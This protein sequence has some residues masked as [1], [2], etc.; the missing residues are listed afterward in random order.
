[1]FKIESYVTP[2]LLSYVDKYVRDFKPADAQVSLWGGG[3][4]LHNLVLKADVLQQEVALPFTLVSGRI[5]EL[6][7]QV[8]WTKI[9]SEPIVVTIDTIECVL[10][11]NRPAPCDAN[12]PAETTSPK[13]QV[14]EAPPGY[15]QALVRR[16][17][18][19]IALRVHH[20][21]VKYVQDDIVMSL[22]VK[23]VAVDSAGASWHP[24]FADIDSSYPVI[25]RLVRLDDLTLCLDRADSDGKIRYYQEP[26]LYRCQLNFR[27]STK[28]VSAN[29][30]RASSL[31]IQLR[32]SKLGFSVTNDQLIL[33]IRLLRERTLQ[34]EKQPAPPAKTP[35]EPRETPTHTASQGNVSHAA[36]PV[37]Q[38]SWS[39]W[40][41]SW[42]PAWNDR[43]GGVEEAP[44]PATPLPIFI[45]AYLDDISLAYKIME[46]ESSTRKRARS[47]LELSAVHAAV[48]SSI[49]APT[50]MR[51]RFGT[52]LLT[53]CSHG[54][55]VCG[56]L[57]IN[58]TQ[59]LPTMYFKRAG[60]TEDREW[61]WPEELMNEAEKMEYAQAIDE[62]F[63][64]SPEPAPTQTTRDSVQS[65]RRSSA[66][67][68]ED[69][70]ETNPG[71]PEEPSPAEPLEDLDELWLKMAPVL[72]VE[73]NHERAPPQR[74]DN[75]YDN[76]PK[77]FE[78]S[79]WVEI[80]NMNVKLDPVEIRLC[81]G[82]IHRMQV[83]EQAFQDLPPILD[84]ELPIRKL[85]VE[86]NEALL[87][88]LPQRK[89]VI[90]VEGTN[91]TV[92]PFKHGHHGQP[93]HHERPAKFP[94]LLE[95]DIPSAV[96]VINGPLYPHRVCSAACQLPENTGPLFQGARLNISVALPSLQFRLVSPR[97]PQPRPCARTD[98]K[99]LL[100]ILLNKGYFNKRETVRLSYSMKIREA[101]ISGSAARLEAAYQVPASMFSSQ[102]TNALRY[103]SLPSDA[104][105]DEEAVTLDI[106]VE[107]VSARGYLTQSMNTHII[108]LQSARATAFH[109]PKGE[110]LKQAWICCAPESP[111][112]IPYLRL[113][114]QWCTGPVPDALD[115]L[116][117][118]TEP[119]AFS[120]D[121]LFVTFLAYKPHLKSDGFASS[122]DM[123]QAKSSQY[124]QRR[125]PTPPSS[126][127]RSSRG[128]ELVHV[129]TR[130]VESSSE[131]SEKKEQ[132]PEHISQPKELFTGQTLVAFYERLRRM[133]INIELGLVLVYVTST[134][135]SA[136][137]CV[138]IRDAM[139]RHAGI[140]SVLA[141]GLGRISMHSNSTRK[142]LW[143]DIR[144]DGPTFIKKKEPGASEID[145]D[146]F[147]WKLRL[148][149]MSCYTL[150][151]GSNLTEKEGLDKSA[152]GL[153]SQ[154]KLTTAGV[155][156]RTVLELTTTTVTLSVVTK[157]LQIKI[158][159]KTDRT[160]RSTTEK[161]GVEKVKYFQTGVD[162]HP[163]TLKEF[164]RGPVRR[165]TIEVEKKAEKK[166][167]IE[168]LMVGPVVSLGVHMHADTP[169]VVIRIAHDQVHIMGS[170]IHCFK[171]IITLL[172][173]QP[174]ANPR[175]LGHRSLIRTVSEV[176]EVRDSRSE[177][178]ISENPSE[179]I[180]IFE[181]KPTSD[182]A[183]PV[184][185]SFWFQWVVSRVT[186]VLSTTQ[187]KFAL[188]IDD[189]ISTVDLQEHY[190]QW[191]LK[192]SSASIRHY[193]RSPDEW[194]PGVLGGRVLEVREPTNLRDDGH[195]IS[196]TIT[197]AQI[198]NLPESWKAELHPKM[199]ERGPSMDTMWEV[200]ATLS[201]LEAVL[202]PITLEHV[203]LLLQQVSPR[204]YCVLTTEPEH[205]PDQSF[206][207]P[208]MFITAGGI[209]ILI[210]GEEEDAD[211]H[212]TFIFSMGKITVTPHPENPI[213]RRP[214]NCSDP[215]WASGNVE[216]EGRQYDVLVKNVAIKSAQ[217]RQ[218]II[219]ESMQTTKG[220]E[221]PAVKWTKPQEQSVVTPVLHAVDIGVVIAPAHYTSGILACG[222]AVEIN[223]LT[224]CAL[225]VS[226]EQLALVTDIVEDMQRAFEET[227]YS[228]PPKEEKFDLCPY[229]NLLTGQEYPDEPTRQLSTTSLVDDS[230]IDTGTST[231]KSTRYFEDSHPISKKVVS[232]VFA[233]QQWTNASEYLEV[234]FTMGMIEASLYVTDDASEEVAS[235]RPPADAKVATTD[236]R[237][238]VQTEQTN[239]E[240]NVQQ[241]NKSN[242]S[243]RLSRISGSGHSLTDNTRRED[244]A[245]T[246]INIALPKAAKSE[247]NLPLIHMTL[248]QPNLYYWKKKNQ[249]GLQA[250]LFNAWV[251]LGSG[252]TEGQWHLPLLSTAKGVPDPA[253][254]IPPALATMKIVAP[255]GP[256]LGSTARGTM[257][258]D[259]ERPVQLEV[260]LDRIR[261]IKGIFA[262]IDD[263]VVTDSS[264]ELP[265]ISEEHSLYRFRRYMTKHGME[266]LTLQTSQISVSGGEGTFGWDSGSIQIA[267]G[268][269]PSRV[270][271]RGLLCGVLC[272]AGPSSD[273]RHML[274]HPLQLGLD[275]QATWEAWRREELGH[276]SH[277]PSIRSSVN[278]DTVTLDLRPCD[279]VTVNDF[280]AQLQSF[281]KKSGFAQSRQDSGHTLRRRDSS[282]I[283]KTNSAASASSFN[284]DLADHYY[285]DDL[286]SGAFKIVSGGQLPMAY[287]VMV[288]GY[289]VSWRYPHPRAIT[290]IVAFP[291]PGLD[292]EVDCVLELYSPIQIKWMPHTYFKLPV[293]EPREIKLFPSPPEVVFALTWR[294]RACDD[295]TAMSRPFEFNAFDYSPRDD[296]LLSDVS[297]EKHTV[298]IPE[299]GVTAEQLSGVLRVDSYFAPRML[300]RVRVALRL[301]YLEVNL[302]NS[303]PNITSRA[304]AELEGY[305]VSRPLMR[306]H[307]VMSLI[308]RDFASNTHFR[309]QAGSLVVFE[310]KLSAD[311][312]ETSTGA[313][314]QMIEEF[315]VR[316]SVSLPMKKKP[317]V[318]V[319]TSRV[320]I[321]L[322][323]PRVRTL[324]ALVK[325]WNVVKQQNDRT[326]QDKPEEKKQ[327]SFVTKADMAR[328]TAT[329]LEG[330]VALWIH[331]S[332]GSA[333]RVGQEGTDEVVPLG[334]GARMAYRW[335]CPTAKKRLRFAVASPTTD[336]HWSSSIPFVA[337]STRVRLEDGESIGDG[338]MIPGAGIFM[339]VKVEETGASRTMH[340]VGRLTLAN[341]LRNNLLF[342]VRARCNV[343][344]QW[345]TV[346]SGELM[347]E[348]VGRTVI[349]GADC[350]MVLKIKFA[351][352]ET[353]WSG[354]IPLKECPKENVPWLV[355]VPSTGEVPYTSV[356][357]RVT[358]AR[359]DGRVL[360]TVWP[361]YVLHSALPLDTV[362]MITTNPTS[363]STAEL[364]QSSPPTL[365]QTAPGRGVCT[366][367]AAPGTTAARHSLSF[368][369]KNIDCPVTR[370]A[371][372][373]HYG[374][375][376][377]SVFD[378]RAPVADI[379]EIVNEVRQ[380]LNRSATNATS[381]WPYSLVTK[382]WPGTWQPAQLQPR[383]DVTV[384]YQAVRAGGG[385]SLEIQLYPVVL[386][387]NAA[388]IALTLRA[389]DA[390]PLC[391]LEPGHA[392]SL[393]SAVLKKP[394]FMSVEMGR[395]TF[396]SGQL[397]LAKEDPGR[398]GAPPPG[399]LA[400]QHAA[401]FAILCNHKVA[402]LTM[403][404]EIKENINVLGIS[405]SYVLLNRLD[406]DIL[407]S[408]IAVPMEMESNVIL[409]SS[410]Y[411]LVPPTNRDS[412]H[413]TP[414]ARFWMRGRWRGTCPTELRLYICLA[415]PNPT[416]GANIV[417]AAHPPVPIR[418]KKNMSRRAV[419]LVDWRNKS[420][421]V[422][423]TQMKQDGRFLIA[424][425]QDPC[426]QFVA[427]N[428][429][430]TTLSIAQP[431]MCNDE[432]ST[433]NTTA[434][435]EVSGT[436]WWC[437][438][439]PNA[440]IHYSTPEHC[441]RYPPPIPPRPYALPFL[442]FAKA[443]EEV[444]PLWCPA[445]A[446]TDG[447]QLLQLQSGMTVKLRVRTYPHSTL[448]ELRDI[449]HTDIS[450]SDIR[451]R[452]L[453]P[454]VVHSVPS[455]VKKDLSRILERVGG[456][457]TL[458]KAELMKPS[459]ESEDAQSQIEEMRVPPAPD[460][461]KVSITE[462][463]P[464]LA[465]SSGELGVIKEFKSDDIKNLDSFADL[466][467][468][469]AAENDKAAEEANDEAYDDEDETREISHASI[470]VRYPVADW[471][472]TPQ[473]R[474]RFV[475]DGVMVEIAS[476]ADTK[477][478]L[479]LHADRL[480]AHVSTHRQKTNTTI[481]ISDVQIDNLQYD[482]GQYDF[483][484]VASTRN[485]VPPQA[486][487]P[488]IWS[489][490]SNSDAFKTNKKDA[491]MWVMVQH[492]M[493]TVAGYTYNE[494]TEVEMALGPLAL[495]IEDAYVNALV[496][497][498]RL[499]A[500]RTPVSDAAAALCTERILRRPLRLRVLHI[501]PLDLTLTLHTAVRMY[502]ALDQ[503]PLRL[504]AFQVQD[505]MTSPEALT[506][507]LTVHYL[508]AAIL[509]AGWMVGGL[510]L[511]GAPGALAARLGE[512]SG[513]LRSFVSATAAAL[514]RSLSAWA[515]S[516]ARNL[517][518]LAGDEEHA[519]RAAAARRR[520]PQSFMAGLAAGITNFAINI[521]GAVGG[522]AHHPLVGVAVGE[523]ES[524]AA[525]LRRGLLGALTKPLSATADLLAF[526]GHGL[527]SQTGWDPVPQPRIT[528]VSREL[529][530]Q[531]SWRRDCV[532]WCFRLCELTAV[533]GFEVLLDNAPLTILL[534]HKFLVVV[535]PES[536]RIVEM[537]DLKFCSLRPFHGAI[538]ELTVSQKRPVKLES[539][540]AVDEDDEFQVSAAAMARVARY[541]G[542]EGAGT[543]GAGGGETR[544]L[545]FMCAP[546][547]AHA[548]YAALT[549]AI[550]HN[551]DSH[552]SLL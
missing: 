164:L 430:G 291:I 16:I 72:Y 54:K 269:R 279:L 24:T 344:N 253:T 190:N 351:E 492:D 41:W 411:K 98:L 259:V 225:E 372:P 436:H 112:T 165:K 174:I 182:I 191:K 340:L 310:T 219:E 378:K 83:L 533:G 280:I 326:T 426:P 107:E 146:S 91:L 356:W 488:P 102:A 458:I 549:T 207:W 178:T 7:I 491:R 229:A 303:L 13:S 437:S 270:V 133:L 69:E 272:A 50:T 204:T 469:T 147:P 100:H 258:L 332:C 443:R 384:R 173:R 283:W 495:Y 115:Y 263:R 387:C 135:V 321:A 242:R 289:S 148:A 30:R 141:L 77:D 330:R 545:E 256:V 227:E 3:V 143:Q 175:N 415:L 149:D 34:A 198:S 226:V 473:E 261:R 295:T 392:I 504:S 145:E 155:H 206:Q 179:L 267:S 401:E 213:C 53:L 70:T 6:L 239:R 59:H 286:R 520:P 526:A 365:I 5:H 408:A 29:T 353:G 435:R 1:M 183:F 470:D 248:Y 118:W 273:R 543:A 398:Y 368:Q 454:Y 126:S 455:F 404:Y 63:R 89:I 539:A 339:Y 154:I 361:L 60:G 138:C 486:P 374:V 78:Y 317:R 224:D 48:K 538:I 503:S 444:E 389:H 18:S 490:F 377:S 334:S 233:E 122:T 312:L 373:M 134:T 296:P 201:P 38:E 103:T 23:H 463:S 252:E 57:D 498:W 105:H 386:L 159:I 302:H 305:Y 160:S 17:V 56:H 212:D 246:T 287:Q 35:N 169:P 467:S 68:P 241:S 456:D 200:Y 166:P 412:I 172:K 457:E 62:E 220:Q 132:K 445:V 228:A 466:Q 209:R 348:T 355:K 395:E 121:P 9:M 210:T 274:L 278:L 73:Y 137:D 42:L 120:V 535:D 461:A 247:G 432:P 352:Y 414:L 101:N 349:C 298:P 316:G 540:R 427:H 292:K 379:D 450:A 14:V 308:V 359:G 55:C 494:L 90:E 441:K 547:R 300:P 499:S 324:Q 512:A 36:E 513:G 290:R 40:A 501:R 255:N 181:A 10:S 97:D 335:R 451:K 489:L 306:S 439:P 431:V 129:R 275:V 139:E 284:I 338:K 37:R 393:P 15:M 222:P 217:F 388:S 99:L 31:S 88:N 394:F 515:G 65:Q 367:I 266:S 47:I 236:T 163:T 119:T 487:W 500:L 516:L 32:S 525:A 336:W 171:H 366:H 96:V 81:M 49:C 297:P 75:P 477:P 161:P 407:V 128:A 262:L 79:D 194:V 264:T 530:T 453:E 483:G 428:R 506:H 66:T 11:L 28:L 320:R 288:D 480:A 87:D 124:F 144:H 548:L 497:L 185:R 215:F 309:S 276:D 208:F 170:A 186:V 318:R 438:I 464:L 552:F 544:V 125:R 304:A 327:E 354:D 429:T 117:I 425:G 511:L 442:T 130:S 409:R 502:I 21:I 162:F 214:I 113:A 505:M 537:I 440:I 459:T 416:E 314:E 360:A 245:H 509:G 322:H 522:L 519:R 196:I 468:Q 397:E 12:Q 285:K 58:A 424:V 218:I 385:C 380:W 474:A 26:L 240:I 391:K 127:G 532:R 421:P 475:L 448:L 277:S 370:E 235:L 410:T 482:T 193:E 250:S 413:G 423:V 518:I 109:A 156:P 383:C 282:E 20:L 223:L 168:R 265:T 85:T 381:N 254:D 406:V 481:A 4:A 231:T 82:L 417:T 281:N 293:N 39:E 27:V 67:R 527:L 167:S 202:Q 341:M 110:P 294:F 364:P 534:T 514:L 323:V 203:V 371:V 184:K 230:G 51:V 142:H 507:A 216:C 523:T 418:L 531:A 546:V 333:L 197:Q 510:E 192:L 376:D 422:V 205:R 61:S 363:V 176:D 357:C 177:S 86:E 106:T 337:G 541:T 150:E 108:S 180:P 251:G 479:A 485:E 260:S 419:A 345:R 93:T 375:T 25:R 44:Q 542:A 399:Q 104:F 152:S 237:P 517:D 153:R 19:N 94:L 22:N 140:S 84:L 151:I 52:R 311:I 446:V 396:V 307:R 80:C 496:S 211:T 64:A 331:N 33:L 45:T 221:N 347:S 476:T 390:A 472:D 521:L 471:D 199:L 478:L 508:S 433:S 536:E 350:D 249:R 136:L 92:H 346:C 76:P 116:G 449:D 114:V 131:R 8:P 551:A 187:V 420:I 238:T 528:D 524:G 2:I 402:L 232:V 403:Y 123:L 529:R 271:V 465:T 400:E 195:F 358:R 315:N 484:V 434:E 243:E 462:M 493:W 362:V 382:H 325:D 343:V 319:R 95:V 244:V 46:M 452:L 71:Q 158:P 447:E 257:K 234:F 74:Q 157:S 550:H 111:S 313:I 329:A 369:Y 188:E 268:T 189:A 405:S 342:K 328:A 460:A 301:V 43:E 299:S